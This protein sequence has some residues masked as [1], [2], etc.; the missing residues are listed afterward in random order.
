MAFY[1]VFLLWLCLLQSILFI[2]AKVIFQKCKLYLSNFNEL[3]KYLLTSYYVSGTVPGDRNIM[4]N[5]TKTLLS[6][7]RRFTF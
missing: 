1:I 5:E 4:V 3:N 6:V 2:E 7:L